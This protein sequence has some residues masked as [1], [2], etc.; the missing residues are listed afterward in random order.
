MSTAASVLGMEIVFL[1][2]LTED[3][4]TFE[5]VKASAEWPGIEEGRSGPREGSL[6]HRLL[7]GAP[8][9]TTDAASDPA[10]AD[11]AKRDELGIRSYVGVPIRN[12]SGQV[13]ATLCGIDRGTVE[14][15]DEAFAVLQSLA[16]VI[17]AHLGPLIAEGLVIR[18]A[19]EGG[20][21]IGDHHTG[22]LTSAMVLADLL[23]SELTPGTRPPKGETPADEVGQ[24]RMSV[25]QLEHALAARVVVEQA[26]GVAHRAASAARRGRRSSGCARWP[27]RVVARCTTCRGRSACRRPTRRCRCRR[28]WP[29]AAERHGAG[30]AERHGVGAAER[31][32]AGAA[33][34]H[35]AGP[36]SPGSLVPR[37]PEALAQ[38]L[39]ALVASD[40]AS[41]G[42]ARRARRGTR[43]RRRRARAGGAGR[44][45]LR[46]RGQDFLRPAGERFEQ[47]REDEE[48]FRTRWLDAAALEREVLARSATGSYLP[49]LWDAERDRSYRRA[50]EPVP[51][52]AVVLVDGLF[53][54]GRSLSCELTVH[55]AL[56]SSALGAG[57]CRR[58]SCRPSR[59]TTGWS[60]RARP[61]TCSCGP[62]TRADRPC[63]SARSRPRPS[64]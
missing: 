41:C 39:V 11:A 24:L 4:F 6:C 46:V 54:L 60:G 13:V 45:P 27:G 30:A 48:H 16:D 7:A 22:D 37:T 28:S 61:A 17:A 14:V 44:A 20:W 63:S 29:A 40:R 55:L 1:G 56:S 43:C 19:A 64:R 33:E 26:I 49:A 12:A 10:Y 50:R 51:E 53:L 9:R 18:R 21:S 59:R 34:R 36:L 2:G 3:T 58:G 5:K 31:H 38:D 47:G 25:K 57:A 62:R 15:S 52:G 32:G 23:A 35:G 8:A 42:A